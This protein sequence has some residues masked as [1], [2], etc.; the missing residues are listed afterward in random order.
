MI[1]IIGIVCIMISYRC[2]DGYTFHKIRAQISCIF[3]LTDCCI[4]HFF[5]ICLNLIARRKNKG[6]QS[7]CF[8][9]AFVNVSFQL[10]VSFLTASDCAAAKDGF[11]ISSGV[12]AFSGLEEPICGSPTKIKEKELVSAS[13]VKE[14]ISFPPT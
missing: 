5:G 2:C 12:F 10:K 13:V 9:Y 7:V 11:K 8:S 4:L 3:H 14:Q 1:R 6:C